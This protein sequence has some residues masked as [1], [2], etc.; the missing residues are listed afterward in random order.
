LRYFDFLDEN[1]SKNIFYK[2]PSPIDRHND[3]HHSKYALGATLYMPAGRDDFS[4][5]ILTNKY[6]EMNSLVLC[7]ED[8]IK[9]EDVI[10]SEQAVLKGINIIKNAL[11]TGELSPHSLPLIFIRIRNAEHLSSFSKALE[12]YRSILS[13]FVLPKFDEVNGHDYVKSIDTLNQLNDNKYW[14]MPILESESIIFSETRKVALHTI[15][16]ILDPY[17]DQILNIRIGAT[18]FCS[19]FGIRRG[20]DVTI[21]QIQVVSECITDI[22]NFFARS[23]SSYIVSGPVWEYFPNNLRLLKPLL[24]STPFNDVLGME[25]LDFRKKLIEYNLDGLI[26][27]IILDKENGFIGKTVIHP[28]HLIMVNALYVVTH[29]EY[30]DAYGILEENNSGGVFKST[31]ENKMNE[32]K[33]H[34][35]WAKKIMKRAEVYGVFNKGYDYLS[36]LSAKEGGLS[37]AFDQQSLHHRS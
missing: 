33:P 32:I 16:D 25:G 11:D 34:T 30:L 26:R 13:G 28:S 20:K 3:L 17:E 10:A 5:I 35:Q 9:D 7:L 24:R 2:K 37:E 15:K 27:E 1:T 22:L 12:P 8:A 36:I 4:S 31:Y 21:Y 23:K 19:H 18:D 14:F 29:E 6:P